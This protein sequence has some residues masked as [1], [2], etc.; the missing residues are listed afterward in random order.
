MRAAALVAGV[1]AQIQEFF[2]VQVPGFQI[3]ADSALAFATLVD[4]NRCVVDDLQKRN[5]ALA[6]PVGAFDPATER[7]HRS[8]VVAQ[9][10]CIFLQQ[11][12]F[13]DALVDVFKIIGDGGQ[14]A[15]R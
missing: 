13:L 5:N 2:D 7:P 6:L 8:P 1:L 12:V 3:R 4:C 15:G 11:G 9:S 10:A 14:V